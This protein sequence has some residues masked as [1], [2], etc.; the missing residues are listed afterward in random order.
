MKLDPRL[1]STEDIRKVK[2]KLPTL[3]GLA[4]IFGYITVRAYLNQFNFQIVGFLNVEY[5]AAGTLFMIVYG[6]MFLSV[7]FL[8]ID[9]NENEKNAEFFLA[10]ALRILIIVYTTTFLTTEFTRE[11][12]V[13]KLI[14]GSGISLVLA[15]FFFRNK[16]FTNGLTNLDYHIYFILLMLI[17]NTLIYVLYPSSRSLIIQMLVAGTLSLFVV[18]NT[19]NKRFY[20]VQ[21][22]GIIFIAISMATIFGEKIYGE[23]PRNYGGAK[24]YK[25]SEISI[26]MGNLDYLILNNVHIVFQTNSEIFI[27][28]DS[29]YSIYPR[30]KIE[31]VKIN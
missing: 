19:F 10:S 23:I 25:V 4:Y 16:K 15:S 12:I 18:S 5:L 17:Y 11:S 6:S 7:Y 13:H 9:E 14:Y 31:K 8:R 29:I 22:L 26:S 28:S 24:S 2:F 27:K 30:R 21:A 20:K 1:L 3:L